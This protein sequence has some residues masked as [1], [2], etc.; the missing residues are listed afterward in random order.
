MACPFFMPVESWRTEIGSMPAG[1]R[2]V[3][4]G[5]GIVP[6]PD[7]KARFRRTVTC[8]SSAILDMRTVVL[9]CRGTG[10]GIRSALRPELS[11]PME[12]RT[13]VRALRFAMSASVGIAPLRMAG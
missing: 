3:A 2:S 6:P 8:T 11:A 4:A 12:A 1:F 9:G 7:R 10:S 13:R 5:A